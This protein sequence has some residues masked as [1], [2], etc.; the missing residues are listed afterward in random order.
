MGAS[1]AVPDTSP[2]PCTAWVSPMEKFAPSTKTG[3]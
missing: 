2:S 1:M 3:K